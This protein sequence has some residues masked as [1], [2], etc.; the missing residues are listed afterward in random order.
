MGRHLGIVDENGD[1]G[2]RMQHALGLDLAGDAR[3]AAGMDEDEPDVAIGIGDGG[4]RFAYE[5]LAAAELLLQRVG[6]ALIERAGMGDDHDM[7]RL[8]RH[9]RIVMDASFDCHGASLSIFYAT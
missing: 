9:H 8:L 5:R 2:G 4:A 1:R 7:R 3:S 6:Q